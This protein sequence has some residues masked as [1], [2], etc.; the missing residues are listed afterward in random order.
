MVDPQTAALASG[1][2]HIGSAT[3]N[4]TKGSV[5]QLT[6]P[7]L[8][9]AAT[10]FFIGGAGD[11]TS[12]YFSGPNYNIRHALRYF[13]PR[14]NDLFERKLYVSSWL[15][16]YEVHSKSDIKKNVMDL[17]PSKMAPIYIVGHSLGA[18]NGAHVSRVL[19]DAGY[20]VVMLVTL[21]PV[22]GGAMVT[23]GSA[24][25]RSP[26]P[27]PNAKVWINVRGA[28][29][30]PDPS[31][32]V[33]NFGDRWIIKSGPNVNVDVD[34][35]HADAEAMFKTKLANGMTVPDILE[36]S[37]RSWTSKAVSRLSK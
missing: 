7:S 35:N 27:N 22:G 13:D 14:V 30:H 4:T 3:T 9:E 33:A 29:K 16:Y 28:P 23:L 10:V 1:D 34:V 5:V 12:Y 31:D 37:I 32:S 8:T 19:K 11:K 24:I 26:E 17:I 18:W 15:G 36:N 25:F 2:I 20:N 6:V 21:D